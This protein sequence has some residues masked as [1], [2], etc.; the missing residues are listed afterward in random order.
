M[1]KVPDLC[2]PPFD[3]FCMNLTDQVEYVTLLLHTPKLAFLPSS[4]LPKLGG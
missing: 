3:T 4:T 1:L 2:I